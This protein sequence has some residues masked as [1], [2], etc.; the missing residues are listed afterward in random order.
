MPIELDLRGQRVEDGLAALDAYLDRA[1]LS[2]L[3][4]VRVIHGHGTGA[5]KSAV[6]EALR[7]HPSVRRS[8]P[9]EKGEGGDGAT[10]VYF[11]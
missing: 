10:V 11:E 7:A 5:M 1:V 3:P 6:R 8:R 2:G 9:G 4:W